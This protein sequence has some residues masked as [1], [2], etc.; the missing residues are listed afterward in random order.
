MSAPPFFTGLPMSFSSVHSRTSIGPLVL[1][2]WMDKLWETT[3]CHMRTV[4][5]AGK[6]SQRSKENEEAQE[7]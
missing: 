1:V 6:V 7:C 2:K 5:V 3:N 4:G